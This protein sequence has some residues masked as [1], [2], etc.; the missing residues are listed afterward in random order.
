MFALPPGIILISL[1]YRPREEM[2]ANPTILFSKF[3]GCHVSRAS[4][5]KASKPRKLSL[6]IE[7]VQLGSVFY[8]GYLDIH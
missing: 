8:D 5:L 6:K 7:F 4:K 3:T 2:L 1:T